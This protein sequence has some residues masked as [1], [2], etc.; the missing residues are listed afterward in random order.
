MNFSRDPDPDFTPHS[1][2]ANPSLLRELVESC[3]AVHQQ[4]GQHCPVSIYLD[5]LVQE[6]RER[7]I[8]SQRKSGGSGSGFGLRS[9][10]GGLRLRDSGT[11]QL[12]V[13]QCLGVELTTI[14]G[15]NS[16]L[17]DRRLGQFEDRLRQHGLETGLMVDFHQADLTEGLWLAQV[18]GDT[19]RSSAA[20]GPN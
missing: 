16:A 1:A 19:S 13:E 14:S 15:P 6:L 5:S 2:A 10:V 7:G 20:T 8:T 9:V 17:P 11:F 12:I 4:L 3:L 18:K